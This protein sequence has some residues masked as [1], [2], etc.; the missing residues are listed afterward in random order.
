MHPPSP[1]EPFEQ[2]LGDL[3]ALGVRPVASGGTAYGMMKARTNAR[4]WLMPLG[5]G[6][7]S[8]ASIAMYQPA[9]AIARAARLGIRAALRAGLTCGWSSGR[10]R[11][12]RSPRLP[13]GVLPDL[14]M[15]AYFTGTAGPHRK[16]AIQFMDAGGGI[17]GYAKLSRNS[18]VVPFLSH[19]A[20]MLGRLDGMRLRSA[21]VPKLL[22]FHGFEGDAPSL[23][24]TDS[25]KEAGTYSP[26]DPRPEHLRFLA[27]L[28][29][30]TGSRGALNAG[31]ELLRLARDNRLP[32]AWRHRFER[33]LDELRA[34]LPKLPLA[35]AHGDFTPWNSFVRGERLYVFDWEYA[36]EDLPLGYD[37]TH[38]VL[39]ARGAA[40]PVG[41]AGQLIA[42]MGNTFP[43]HDSATR[44]ALVLLSL[45]LHAGFYLCRAAECQ[46]DALH[47][48]DGGVRGRL[49]DVLLDNGGALAC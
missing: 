34:S 16:T 23:L 37:L 36:S 26:M 44:H 8:S 46:G 7:V 30:R 45:L 27:E 48:A 3:A 22:V 6:R 38:Y 25:R 49:I 21:D 43:E 18:L 9:S 15:C 31:G 10:I 2:F 12:D 4:W 29:S 35:L 14:A 28:A 13:D 41:T 39:A 11:F 5:A 19:E 47:W 32:T 33:G 17:L 24:V 42:W 20:R 1:A 40:D